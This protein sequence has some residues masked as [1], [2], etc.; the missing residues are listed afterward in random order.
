MRASESLERLEQERGHRAGKQS[1]HR[2]G[3]A[4]EVEERGHRAGSSRAMEPV[5]AGIGLLVPL[6]PCLCSHF[7]WHELAAVL[8]P[9]NQPT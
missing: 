7:R 3:S 8:A 5:G 2:A 9:G 1:G 6:F 4:D